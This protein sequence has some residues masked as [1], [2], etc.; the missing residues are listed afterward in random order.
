MD[1]R[2]KPSLIWPILII[3]FWLIVSPDP[4]AESARGRIE[5]ITSQSGLEEGNE[6]RRDVEIDTSDPVR[7]G[8]II[9][10][11]ST[12]TPQP[13]PAQLP[14]EAPTQF[15]PP[16]SGSNESDRARSEPQRASEG[17]PTAQP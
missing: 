17:R 2:N 9:N 13:T 4:I 12:Q 1:R 11:L 10:P 7:T 8:P 6:R 3:V 14:T 15:Q 16:E 5:A